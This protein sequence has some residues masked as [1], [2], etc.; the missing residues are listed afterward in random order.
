MEQRLDG[1]KKS[2][3]RTFGRSIGRAVALELDQ[4]KAKAVGGQ[5]FSDGQQHDQT[6]RQESGKPQKAGDLPARTTKN[7][8]W[9]TSLKRSLGRALGRRVGG[10]VLEKEDDE[11]K[12]EVVDEQPVQQEAQ[13]AE[14]G[15]KSLEARAVL[16]HQD[17]PDT[18]PP[19]LRLKMRSRLA[20]LGTSGRFAMKSNR[21]AST[22]GDAVLQSTAYTAGTSSDAD[23][24]VAS[25]SAVDSAHVAHEYPS[26]PSLGALTACTY[27]HPL[28][29]APRGRGRFATWSPR[30]TPF[31]C[32]QAASCSVNEA[33]VRPV[34]P[35]SQIRSS[36]VPPV[37]D[38]G[39][40]H[41]PRGRS[42][43]AS[44]DEV[45]SDNAVAP[46]S[47]ED[48]A[49]TSSANSGLVQAVGFEG[50]GDGT[51]RNQAVAGA[52]ENEDEAEGVEDLLPARPR[53]PTLQE[54]VADVSAQGKVGA[55][56]HGAEIEEG[57][58]GE[59]PT[60]P[61]PR[62]HRSLS[63]IEGRYARTLDLPRS[64]QKLTLAEVQKKASRIDE[65]LRSVPRFP[66]ETVAEDPQQDEDIQAEAGVEEEDSEQES[67]L[68]RSTSQIVLGAARGARESR[69]L[70]REE[71]AAHINRLAAPER[72]EHR[73]TAPSPATGPSSAGSPEP[74]ARPRS[75]FPIACG[76]DH[77]RDQLYVVTTRE[78]SSTAS[79]GRSVNSAPVRLR[80]VHTYSTSTREE[81]D[82]RAQKV[83]QWRTEWESRQMASNGRES[84]MRISCPVPKTNKGYAEAE[85]LE[86]TG[87]DPGAD[88]QTRSS[89]ASGRTCLPRQR[90][91]PPSL[92]RSTLKEDEQESTRLA[93]IDDIGG[94]RENRQ[95]E[96]TDRERSERTSIRAL[97]EEVGSASSD[98][99]VT[100][101]W[102]GPGVGDASAESGGASGRVGDV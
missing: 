72:A 77:G 12:G 8:V 14:D 92:P 23:L 46:H 84:T 74:K 33:S 76:Q 52:P 19:R 83:R 75:R 73:R 41:E 31:L 102:H 49:W 48:S 11:R 80:R 25:M 101:V 24:G 81:S 29:V 62:L 89:A 44:R 30:R 3:K 65:L 95:A 10:V 18:A 58:A 5:Q 7:N 91:E 42:L 93:S 47:E 16:Q 15:L 64:R 21:A 26:K 22:D 100:T 54:G 17:A 4:A 66:L 90:D 68:V 34:L 85:D 98:S 99:V 35:E 32:C 13:A 9:K 97:T 63:R 82:A 56:A 36:D 20:G 38:I 1:W 28:E 71:R 6:Q 86:E 59:L 2:L 96:L 50:V 67:A 37:R 78:G 94:D 53:L 27:P 39:Q 43:P 69:G 61:A 60:G 51:S 88:S 57:D 55:E 87:E 40:E 45:V 70:R 79:T